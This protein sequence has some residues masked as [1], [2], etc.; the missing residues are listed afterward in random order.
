LTAQMHTHSHRLKSLT[1]RKQLLLTC[2][3]MSDNL[4]A[5]FD[6]LLLWTTN[7]FS[8]NGFYFIFPFRNSSRS[9]MNLE[10]HTSIPQ[11]RQWIFNLVDTD[12]FL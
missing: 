8:S 12:F 1:T 10:G 2:L 4:I 9:F 7:S 3:N 5:D 6:Q 11:Y